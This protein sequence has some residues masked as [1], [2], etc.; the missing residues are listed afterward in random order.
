MSKKYEDIYVPLQYVSQGYL[1][2]GSNNQMGRWSILW[3]RNWQPTLIFLPEKSHGWRSLVGYSPRGHKGLDMTGQLHFHFCE[4]H[5]ASFPGA[6]LSSPT[7][8]SRQGWRCVLSNTGF[9]SQ[10]PPLSTWSAAANTEF[11]VGHHTPVW[12]VSYLIATW[13]H[14]V[15]FTLDTA[16]FYSYRNTQS[17]DMNLPSLSI[18][19]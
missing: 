18:I 6:L 9:H 1:S 17:L 16:A 8:F 15:S 13:L 14:W 10:K 3:R 2:R 11:L 5:S 12:S 19:L 7:G 4:H